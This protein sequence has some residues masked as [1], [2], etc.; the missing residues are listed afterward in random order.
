[1]RIK[2]CG[3]SS[4]QQANK[5]IALG[6]HALGF[7]LYGDNGI[8]PEKAREI[9]NNL[10]PFISVVGVFKDQPYYE[11]EELITFLKLHVLQFDGEEDAFFCSKFNLPVIKA[12]YSST[13]DMFKNFHDYDIAALMLHIDETF[14]EIDI[15]YLLQVKEL[16][17]LIIS[18]DSG[19]AQYQ[20]FID[21][22]NPYAI[23]ISGNVPS[24]LY[25][26]LAERYTS[27]NYS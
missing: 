26:K 8:N 2:F 25:W 16:D 22:L 1:M 6:A 4:Q 11:I 18:I 20:S 27:C 15:K 12:I 5:A 17:N 14:N 19:Q 10:P 7:V 23:N 24:S 13:T 3:I 21:K 9:I